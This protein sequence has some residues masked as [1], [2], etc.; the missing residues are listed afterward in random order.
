[1]I[2]NGSIINNLNGLSMLTSFGGDLTIYSTSL[3]NL[4]GLENIS[5]IGGDLSIIENPILTTLMGLD[6]INSNSIMNLTIQNNNSLSVCEIQSICEYLASPIGE[7]NISGNDT[8]CN[9]KE[10]V[11]TICWHGVPSVSSQQSPV[12]IYPNPTDGIVDLQFTVYNLQSISLKVYDVHGREVAVVLDEKM[13]AGEHTV[14]WDAGKLPS[15]IY[16]YR[17]TTDDFRL[18]TGKLVK[19]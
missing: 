1:V 17:L 7:T 12:S 14:R 2:I 16:F 5:S 18:T 3:V 10:E 8:G 15:G 13:P 11:E 19:Y 9:S 6:S 4:N